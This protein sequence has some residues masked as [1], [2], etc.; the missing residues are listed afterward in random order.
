MDADSGQISQVFQNLVTNGIQAM[1]GGGELEIVARNREIGPGNP[2]LPAGRYVE[3]VVRDHGTGIPRE[4]LDKIF[5][6]FFTTKEKGSG[7]GLAISHSIIRKHLGRIDVESTMGVGTT[8]RVVLP[9]SEAPVVAS[10]AGGSAP[11]G[12]GRILVM[13][14]EEVVRESAAE[15]LGCLG[16]RVEMAADGL[17]ALDHYRKAAG[18]GQ[19]YDAVILDL[20]VPGGMGGRETLERLTELD[21]RVRAIVSS[22]YANDAV[23]ADYRS[24]GFAG[25]ISKPYSLE[26]LGRVVAEV[27]KG[28][29]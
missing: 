15:L 9:A 1:P 11:T 2:S 5:V 12:Q 29:A 22:G 26:D 23:L 10:P 14:D 13:D 3:V 4:Q 19:G 28:A 24:H 7:L 18:A 25:L 8:F 16:Y 17:E 20:T 6:P 21:P 27:L